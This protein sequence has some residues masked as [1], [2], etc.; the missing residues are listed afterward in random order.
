LKHNEP[1][2]KRNFISAVPKKMNTF[3]ASVTVLLT[4]CVSLAFGIACAWVALNGML[5]AFGH[6]PATRQAAVASSSVAV[7]TPG[8]SGS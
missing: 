6:R 4:I 5:Y 1:D 2:Q 8:M 3:L 7:A